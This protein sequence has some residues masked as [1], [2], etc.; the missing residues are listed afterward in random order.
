MNKLEEAPKP[1]DLELDKVMREE[2]DKA[3]EKIPD[4]IMARR[5]NRLLTVTIQKLIENGLLTEKSNVND[6]LRILRT[7]LDK[8]DLAENTDFIEFAEKI[9]EEKQD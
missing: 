2:A 9:L 8:T 7:M 1:E 6:L 4:E 3:L 5:T